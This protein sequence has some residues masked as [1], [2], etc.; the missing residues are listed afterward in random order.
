M[1]ASLACGGWDG[2]PMGVH[3]VSAS[4]LFPEIPTPF[5]V[6]V[7]RRRGWL[8]YL[9]F[10]HESWNP[11][12][13]GAPGAPAVGMRGGSLSSLW[14]TS[15]SGTQSLQAVTPPGQAGS[16]MAHRIDQRMLHVDVEAG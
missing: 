15:G 7:A 4:N 10:T 14:G 6:K 3:L 8:G 16:Q 1:A 9:R 5:T 2:L 12:A 11:L 13:H